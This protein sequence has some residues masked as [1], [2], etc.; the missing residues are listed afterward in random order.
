MVIIFLTYIECLYLEYIVCTPFLDCLSSR[1]QRLFLMSFV[2]AT[3]LNVDMNH[4][5]LFCGRFI[6]TAPQIPPFVESSC[7][8]VKLSCS[9]CSQCFISQSTGSDCTGWSW[10]P[11]LLFLSE[12]S[13]K[14]GL[15]SQSR[16][17]SSYKLV[18]ILFIYCTWL[19]KIVL[20]SLISGTK[21]KDWKMIV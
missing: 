9:V 11:H 15:A 21:R 12:E 5:S 7:T 14:S 8:F 2:W 3:A 19:C 16:L 13:L 4:I 20:F 10:C 1:V 6:F 18:P 17:N